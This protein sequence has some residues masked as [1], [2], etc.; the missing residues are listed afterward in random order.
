MAFNAAIN[1]MGVGLKHFGGRA[2]YSP[3]NDTI[4]LPPKGTFETPNEYYATAFHECVH[5]TERPD[6][7]DWSRKNRNN[8]YALGELIA[9]LGGVF[10]C[11]E[12]NVPA[13][14]DLSNHTAYLANWLA[15]M[16]NDTRF[17]F[18]ASAQANK[19]ASYLLGF[20]HKSDDA[21]ELNTMVEC[22]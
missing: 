11:R 13:S 16:K 15:A 10:V 4:V 12:L 5:A 8:T 19:A 6:R 7:L 17:I 22:I 3:S 21:T 1:G 9:E 18:Q 20:S 2:F 14:D